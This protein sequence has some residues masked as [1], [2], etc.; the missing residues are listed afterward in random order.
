[1]ETHFS[2]RSHRDRTFL[3]LGGFYEWI[4]NLC[5]PVGEHLDAPAMNNLIKTMPKMRRGGYYPPVKQLKSS[6]YLSINFN[7]RGTIF[8]KNIDFLDY[9]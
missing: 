9:M 8:I 4:L 6:A 7:D 1:M 2:V 3:F 5:I